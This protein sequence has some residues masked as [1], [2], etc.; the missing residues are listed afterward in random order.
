M[1]YGHIQC[2]RIGGTKMALNQVVTFEISFPIK[3]FIFILVA[4][5]LLSF[6]KD[7]G[8]RNSFL[9]F[10]QKITHFWKKLVNNKIFT[11]TF[12][13]IPLLTHFLRQRFFIF[14]KNSQISKTPHVQRVLQI[15][16]KVRNIRVLQIQNQVESVPCLQILKK[17]TSATDNGLQRTGK[18]RRVAFSGYL[19]RIFWKSQIKYE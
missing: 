13:N 11:S 12:W 3:K 7:L 2:Q 14:S 1:P 18:G 6:K 4:R 9:T 10:S 5:R 15:L 16:K 8:P 17:S 19:I